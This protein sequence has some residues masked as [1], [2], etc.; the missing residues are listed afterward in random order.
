MSAANLVVVFTSINQ[1]SDLNQ[2]VFLT[3]LTLTSLPTSR[4][5]TSLFTLHRATSHALPAFAAVAERPRTSHHLHM[6][7][8]S[9]SPSQTPHRQT[10]SQHLNHSLSLTFPQTFSLCHSQT[11]EPTQPHPTASTHTRA[12]WVPSG[13][14]TATKSCS[15]SSWIRSKLTAVHSPQP[16]RR[17]T[18]SGRWQ[19]PKQLPTKPA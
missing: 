17:S 13:P 5:L 4:L 9:P 18:V 2:N 15:C 19:R 10:C 8:G 16:G 6:F 1:L 11:Y 7:A 12:R 14:P 3:F